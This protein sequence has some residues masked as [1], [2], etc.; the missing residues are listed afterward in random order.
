MHPFLIDLLQCPACRG[1]LN[2]HTHQSTP[3]HIETAEARC[4]ACGV[5]YPVREGIASFLTPDLPR[6][7]LWEQV[8]SELSAYLATDPDAEAALMNA[9]HRAA[10][11]SPWVSGRCAMIKI[12]NSS[13]SRVHSSR[14]SFRSPKYFVI[15]SPTGPSISPPLSGKIPAFPRL[16]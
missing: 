14:G 15:V 6:D 10:I 1:L 7:D 13:C 8:D 12:S 16:V 4:A 9:L 5:T 11:G 2:W 3:E